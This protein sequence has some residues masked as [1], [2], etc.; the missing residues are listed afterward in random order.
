MKADRSRGFAPVEVMPTR[1][2]AI[3]IDLHVAEVHRAVLQVDER[4]VEAGVADDLDDLRVGEHPDVGPDRESALAHNSL[5]SVLLHRVFPSGRLAGALDQPK[6]RLEW[7]QCGL[8]TAPRVGSAHILG[9]L[10]V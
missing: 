9:N 10:L 2:A 3:T 6:R 5:D 7:R 8:R 1:S 4:R